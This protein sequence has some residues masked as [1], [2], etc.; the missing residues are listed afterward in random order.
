MNRPIGRGQGRIV[1]VLG[2]TN[3]GKT[4]YAVERML[5]HA[6]GM[7]G[8]PLRLLAREIYDRVVA[9]RGARA[10]ALLT[11]EE[12]ILPENPAYYICTVESMPLGE[13]VDFVAVDEIQLA[14]D[15]QRGH[16]FTDRLLRARG[17][18]ETVFLGSDT[19]RPIVARLLPQAAILGRPRLSRL[20]YVKPRKLSRL[21]PRSAVIAY[22]AEDVYALAELLRR[23]HGGV[24]VV[25]GALSPRTRNAQ[26]ALY[27]NGDVDYL[28]AT[29]AIGMGLNMD[30]DHVA[31]AQLRKFDGRRLRPLEAAE[32][33]QVAGRAG[34]HMNDGT[35][36]TIAGAEGV[37][38]D[39][40]MIARVE[41]HR[42]PP[43][44]AI[45]WRNAA[46]DFRSLARL[47]ASL[48]MA[49]PR[50]A[51]VRVHGATDLAA[52]KA[53]ATDPDIARLTTTPEAIRRL[54]EVCQIPDFRK[55]GDTDHHALLRR[56]HLQ[57]SA[58]AG[59]IDADW[60]A[61]EVSRLD[62]VQGDIDSLAAR[63]ARIRIWTY[64]ANRRDWLRDPAHWAAV[65]RAVENRLSDALHERLTQRFVDRRTTLLLRELRQK[66]DLSVSI[67]EGNEIVVEG[68]AIGRVEGFSFR[69][70][71]A[72][73]GEEHRKLTAAA[74]AALAQEV[75]RRA[76][77]F[78]N[79]G[80]QTLELDL[81]GGLGRPRLVWQ[82]AAIAEIVK[83]GSPLAPRVRLCSGHLLGD[84]DAVRVETRCAAWLEARLED[85]LGP[86]RALARVLADACR[87]GNEGAPALSGLAR[88]I[89]FRLVENYGILR[90]SEVARE[91][92]ELDADARRALRRFKLRI[93]ATA[94]YMPALLKPH[95][96]E[97]R[98]MLWALE[99][100]YEDLPA[101]PRPGLVWIQIES[102]G[103]RGFYDLAGFR[104]IG[105]DE[106]VRLDMLERLAD[107][108]RPLGQEG[109]EFAAT[110]EI[111]GL[112][113]CSGDS[114]LRTMRVIGYDHRMVA[115]PAR[116][117][118]AAAESTA[119]D[120]AGAAS[121][122]EGAAEAPSE[123][124]PEMVEE[125][126]FFWSPQRPRPARKRPAGAKG[127]AG[128][129]GARREQKPE[130]SARTAAAGKRAKPPRAPR[131]RE[132]EVDADS[133]FAKLA[134][135]RETL[136]RKSS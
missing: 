135:L 98:L 15:P 124:T 134:A 20:R 50:Q 79:I 67:E 128:K 73:L 75:A 95:A 120:E 56:I 94:L 60:I 106:A 49:A 21:P 68:H 62:N 18:A 41:E 116:G 47:I 115:V 119:Q 7:M 82:G 43:L 9:I 108:V 83:G 54:W 42:F 132:P 97:L 19:I 105:K 17:R 127:G 30:I 91:L 74:E 51:F 85:K 126:R 34:R 84:A 27:Q 58:P 102:G 8:F 23:R 129:A 72:E 65:T 14:A 69:P 39:P 40:G 37:A 112:V 96:V 13:P 80:H 11:G 46:L 77:I 92:R 71:V 99:N 48:E 122:A 101:I 28:V 26:V 103:P 64:V 89:A 118:A 76:R 133:P 45:R 55:L 104:P 35:F 12:K 66:G 131:R 136:A 121:A 78:L 36:S 10:V 88:G 113:G 1:A 38:L 87:A 61:R 57:L 86:L 25:M 4:H 2:P 109:A 3:T 24:A 33:A 130:K 111:M 110:P 63:I 114:F 52:L 32:I 44:R 70:A 117:E 90:R 22:S 29:D 31:F 125:P 107:A 59:V 53:L 100:G 5:G 6:S 93:G 123:A 16:V 81:S